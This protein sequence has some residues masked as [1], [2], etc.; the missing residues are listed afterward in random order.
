MP[1]KTTRNCLN[2]NNDK[3]TALRQADGPEMSAL[4]INTVLALWQV[5]FEARHTYGVLH[6]RFTIIQHAFSSSSRQP[7]WIAPSPRCNMDTH[8]S[9]CE[10][11]PSS[12]LSQATGTGGAPTGNACPASA[13]AAAPAQIR[14]PNAGT[15]WVQETPPSNLHRVCYCEGP[16]ISRTNPTVPMQ[17][18]RARDTGRTVKGQRRHW[19]GAWDSHGRHVRATPTPATLVLPARKMR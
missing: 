18:Q 12:R 6:G 11:V 10:S 8:N 4:L 7:L 2:V 1:P 9:S 15:I 17:G 14:L 19:L 5:L 13:H 16:S 3:Q